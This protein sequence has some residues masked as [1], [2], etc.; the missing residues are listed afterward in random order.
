M[1]PAERPFLLVGDSACSTPRERAQAALDAWLANWSRSGESQRVSVHAVGDCAHCGLGRRIPNDA[2]YEEIAGTRVKVWIMRDE[3]ARS[4]LGRTVLGEALVDEL[5]SSGAWVTEVLD[6][7]QDACQRTLSEALTGASPRKDFTWL[8]TPPAALFAAG[9]GALHI[10][11]RTLGLHLYADAAAWRNE[12]PPRVHRSTS[13][14]AAVADAVRDSS[15]RLEV[16][17]GEVDMELSKITDLR[18][19][20]VL[21]L[22]QPLAAGISVLCEGQR[23]ASGS[24][25]EMLGQK[26]VQ[27]TN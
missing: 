5:G 20:D 27:L 14:L 11:C 3:S 2:Q 4:E 18:S 9:S 24:L 12:L 13:P 1:T 8:D 22:P 17:L 6:A 23:L 10:C 15:A 26:C 7:A 16:R 25:G 19:G 21:R